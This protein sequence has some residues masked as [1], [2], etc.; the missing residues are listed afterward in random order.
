MTL[1]AALDSGLAFAVVI[2]FFGVIYPGWSQGFSWWGT[3]VYKQVSFPHDDEMDGR[4]C[5][6]GR[7]RRNSAWRQIKSGAD[8]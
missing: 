1:S 2:I 3:E 5:V 8:C 6:V 4:R 7:E